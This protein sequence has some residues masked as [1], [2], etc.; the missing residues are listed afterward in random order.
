M[1]ARLEGVLGELERRLRGRVVRDPAVVRLY[2]REPSGLSGGAGAVVFPESVEDVRVLVRWAYRY[3]VPL[4]PQGSGTSL[5]GS[6][7]PREPGVVVSFERMRR[8][9]EVNVVDGVAVVEPGVRIDELNGVLAS[10]GYMFPV[11]PASAAVATVGGAINSGAGGMRGAKYGTMRDWVLGLWVV[12]ADEGASHVFLGCRTV[13]CRQGYDLVRLIVGSEGTLALV[14]RAILRITPLPEAVVY[15]LAFY[16]SLEDL[17]EA[18]VDIKGSGVQPLIME[19]MDAKTVRYAAEA[20]GVEFDARGHMLL[21]GVDVNREAVDRMLRWLVE[22][23]GRHGARS[24]LTARSTEEAEERG[25][26]RVRR[27][28]FTAQVREGQERLGPGRRVMVYIEDIVVPPSRLVEAVRGIRELEE[29][30]G[31]TVMLGGHIGDGNLHPAVAFDPENPEEARRV[32]EWFHEVMELALR[33]GGSVSAEHGIGLMKRKGLAMEL[34]A[35]GGAER[36]LELMRGV[37][38]VF[39]PKGILNPGKVVGTY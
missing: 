16:D 18:V 27:N 31:F 7:V 30:Y 12:L 10:R 29:K 3:G 22:T 26:F 24:I 21:V 2:A 28:L 1:G 23:L 33:L 32:E 38:R 34:E 25:L 39:D 17:A 4:Y 36:I 5:S 20:A 37:K 8:I 15:A 35:H 19:F 6:A 13:K 14:T 11:D 9:L